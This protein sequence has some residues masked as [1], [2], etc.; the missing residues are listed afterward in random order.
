MVEWIPAVV[1]DNSVVI[2]RHYGGWGGGAGSMRGAFVGLFFC[3]PSFLVVLVV[4]I[5]IFRILLPAILL[6]L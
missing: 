4:H 5:C 6:L 3:V 2:A 1:V